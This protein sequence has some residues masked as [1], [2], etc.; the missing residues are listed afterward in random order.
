MARSVRGSAAAR[1]T[2]VGVE[3]L[4]DV[5]GQLAS[6]ERIAS[7]IWLIAMIGCRARHDRG[8]VSRATQARSPSRTGQGI[9][10]EGARISMAPASHV[11]G[12]P[13]WGLVS[14]RGRGPLPGA[15][16]PLRD[17]PTSA[18]TV[19]SRSAD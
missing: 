10:L 2:A 5:N 13:F 19:T 12:D 17:G 11:D 18:A 16:K 14:S 7:T 3:S 1:K 15:R 6:A 8:I 9:W 4:V